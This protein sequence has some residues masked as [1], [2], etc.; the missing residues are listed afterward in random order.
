MLSLTEE[1]DLPVV[2]VDDFPARPGMSS[3]IYPEYHRYDPPYS[4]PRMIMLSTILVATI[5]VAT[6]NLIQ[7]RFHRRSLVMSF[8]AAALPISSLALARRGAAYKI[9]A[10]AR[11]IFL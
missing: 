5:H 6:V 8:S 4:R 7:M 3:G 10:M 9:T 11:S 1:S 2:G